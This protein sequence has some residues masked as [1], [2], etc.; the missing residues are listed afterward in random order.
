MSHAARALRALDV[1]D[2]VPPGCRGV[3]VGHDRFAPHIRRGEIA[4]IDTTDKSPHRGE[5]YALWIGEAHP[6]PKLVQ[7]TRGRAGGTDG[8]FFAFGLPEPG[9]E[10]LTDGPLKRACWPEKCLGRVVGVIEP[11]LVSG[12]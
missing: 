7:V 5:I 4:V 9:R 11:M 1:L 2:T 12:G 3:V 10:H 8:L 6:K